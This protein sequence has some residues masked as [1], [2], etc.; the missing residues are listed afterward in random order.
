[1]ISEFV[2]YIFLFDHC[3]TLNFFII[4]FAYWMDIR[5]EFRKYIIS[6]CINNT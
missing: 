6:I 5:F 1:M 2:A 3:F 4:F